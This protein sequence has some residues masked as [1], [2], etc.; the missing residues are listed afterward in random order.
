MSFQWEEVQNTWT[1]FVRYFEVEVVTPGYMRVGWARI[2]AD[3][4]IELGY[5]A[6]S[7]GFDGYLVRRFSSGF[8][9]ELKFFISV[10]VSEGQGDVM[11]F[12]WL[13]QDCGLLL[14]VVCVPWRSPCLESQDCHLITRYYFCS[15]SSAYFCVSFCLVFFCV[16]AHSPILICFQQILQYF[17]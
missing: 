17:S 9:S 6:N 2:N 14:C 13:T 5:G 11:W 8:H 1:V 15:C 12:M 10:D 16:M 3:P 4:S 7:Y